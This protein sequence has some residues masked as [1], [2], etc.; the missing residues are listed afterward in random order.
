MESLP[1]IEALA[2][3][4]P[5]KPNVR[6]DFKSSKLHNFDVANRVAASAKSRGCIPI[7]S[8]VT[9]SRRSPPPVT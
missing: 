7:P 5:R 1:T 9:E 8:S 3:A 4:S 6:I 2:N